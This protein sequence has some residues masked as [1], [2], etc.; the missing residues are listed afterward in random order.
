MTP[1]NE[2]SF[3]WWACS[4][5][6]V[7]GEDEHEEC[8]GTGQALRKYVAVDA[9]LTGDALCPHGWPPEF[10]GNCHEDAALPGTGHGEAS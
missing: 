8:C 10:C 2:S 1:C 4:T 9:L 5:C 7:L 6:G 3:E